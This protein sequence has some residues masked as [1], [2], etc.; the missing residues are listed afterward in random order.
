MLVVTIC[1]TGTIA[2]AFACDE[3]TTRKPHERHDEQNTHLG[4]LPGII[5]QDIA[6]LGRPEQ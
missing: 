3:R 5:R 1:T 2:T 6:R 4:G